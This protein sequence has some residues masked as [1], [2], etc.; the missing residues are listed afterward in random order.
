[1]S[2]EPVVRVRGVGPEP[3]SGVQDDGTFVPAFSGQREPFRPGHALRATHGAYLAAPKL[4]PRVDELA[5]LIRPLVPVYDPSDEP[6]IRLLCLALAR[7]ERSAA[8]IDAVTV[9]NDE[10][11]ARLRQ[12][13]RGWANTCRRLLGD[14]GMSPTSR[15]RLGLDLTRSLS[16]QARADALAEGRALRLDSE[17]AS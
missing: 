6:V 3:R 16:E 10:S 17:A 8:A 14:L 7:L 5:D 9:D 11:V 4:G 13:E 15:A 2:D 1:M 12:D